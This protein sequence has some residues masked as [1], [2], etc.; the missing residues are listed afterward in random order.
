FGARD[1]DPNC[2]R[3]LA[4]DPVRFAAAIQNMYI[5][6]SNDPIG[7]IDPHGAAPFCNH[8]DEPI[9]VGG[10]T[11]EGRGH[12]GDFATGYVAPGQCVDKDHPL[13]TDTGLLSDVDVAD[14]N[15]DGQV[16]EPQ[17]FFDIWPFGEKVL[18]GSTGL[19]CGAF[20]SHVEGWNIPGVD[21]WY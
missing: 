15:G 18:G 13:E 6:V 10:G 1:Y 19:V 7:R 21:G 11:G 2:A 12:D 3:W 5:Y 16:S 8:T 4:R 9:L 14:F 17:G 20:E